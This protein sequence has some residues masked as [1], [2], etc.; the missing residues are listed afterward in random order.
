ML[1]YGQD[2][3]IMLSL[4]VASVIVCLFGYVVL[5]SIF[6]DEWWVGGGV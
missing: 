4:L 2:L 1:P 3:N 5:R 6:V